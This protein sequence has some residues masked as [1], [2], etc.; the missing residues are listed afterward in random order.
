MT[1]LDVEGP[2]DHVHHAAA[3]EEGGR[4]QGDPA[5][6]LHLS[7]ETDVFPRVTVARRVVQGDVWDPDLKL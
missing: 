2:V 3:V 7:R 5:C 4:H 1:G 6:V